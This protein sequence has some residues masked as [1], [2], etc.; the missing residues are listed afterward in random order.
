MDSFDSLYG[1]L[2][3]GA[4]GDALGLPFERLTPAKRTRLWGDFPGGLEMCFL[5]RRGMVSDDTEHALFTA[6][7]LLESRGTS[8]RFARVLASELRAW[9]LT[10]PPGIGWATLRAGVKALLFLPASRTGVVSAGNGPAM[11]AAILGAFFGDAT[12]QLKEFCRVSTRLTH[13]DPKAEW[14]A[15]A[16]ALAAS[17]ATKGQADGR[18]FVRDLGEWS[19]DSEAAREMIALAK[20]AV[21]SAARGQS[22]ADF[23]ADMGL[24]HGVSGYIFHTVPVVLQCWL[25]HAADFRAGIEEIIRCGGDTDSTAAI[26]G[27]IL[28]AGVGGAQLPAD[29]TSELRDFPNSRGYIERVAKELALAGDEGVTVVTPR[30]LF[31]M[32]LLRNAFFVSVV[33]AHALRRLVPF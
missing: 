17:H 2:L 5:P 12:A 6:R 8:E 31:G 20:R 14:G 13:T 15:F 23:C 7:A 24:K 30:A 16:V 27:G 21:N 22:A 26:L 28:G 1:C 29:W 33:I 10:L 25:R 19:D 9:M 18:R 3:G 32:P 4:L 11:R